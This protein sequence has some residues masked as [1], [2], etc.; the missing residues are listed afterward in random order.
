MSETDTPEG[1]RVAVGVPRE[2]YPC[3]RRVAITPSV[4]PS[5]VKAGLDVL[6]EPGAGRLAGFSDEAYQNKGARVG[7]DRIEVFSADVLVQVR[8]FGANPAKG[9]ADLAL[10]RPGQ[11]VIGLSDPLNRP[12][13]AA[14][15]AERKI[16]SFALE[17]IPRITR[18]QSMDVLSS[19]ATVAGYKAVVL[20]AERVLKLF[21][22]MTTAAGTIVPA[23]VLVIGAGVAGLSAIATARRLGAVVEAYDVRPAAREH[24]ESLGARF[25]ELPLA[26]GDAEDASGYAKAL[27][28]SFYRRQRELLSA[29]VAAVDVVITTAAIPGERAP[30]LIDSAMVEA[31][32]A[33][34]VIVDLA[35]E[36]GGNCELTVADVDVERAGVT[37]LGPTNLAS[38]VAFDA[39]QMFAKN[40]TAFLLSL[41]RDGALVIDEEDEIVR[42]S[43]VTKDGHVVHPKV[44]AALEV[45]GEQAA[46]AQRM[47]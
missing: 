37:I 46:P 25:L 35:A 6:I 23:R 45:S 13:A 3:E 32:H 24:V 39:S 33:G 12:A 8:S 20:A 1:A 40:V 10:M 30:I 14:E 22:L 9:R 31:M 5:F 34:S 16:T 19:Q 4:M 44:L 26:P 21:P 27:G 42:K 43:L 2:S 17:L 38:T 41:V 18:A 47:A 28:E 36:R 15:A 11:I 7:R 29:A